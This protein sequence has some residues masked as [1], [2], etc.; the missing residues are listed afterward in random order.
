MATKHQI[1][2]RFRDEYAKASKRDKS[3]ILDRMCETLGIDRS[4]AK[5][6]LTEA[7][8]GGSAERRVFSQVG[9]SVSGW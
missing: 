2:L 7:L 8:S 3:V 9:V 1:T 4:T 5:R 6:R